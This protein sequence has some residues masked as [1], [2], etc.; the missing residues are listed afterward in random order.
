[1]MYDDVVILVMERKCWVDVELMKQSSSSGEE[2]WVD[3][4]FK[5]KRWKRKGSQE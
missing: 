2:C 5:F 3:E 1:M 4:R